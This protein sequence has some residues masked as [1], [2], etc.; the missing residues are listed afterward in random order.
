MVRRK[1][2]A[3]PFVMNF[4]PKT[5]NATGSWRAPVA[6]RS[7]S[8][9]A[10]AAAVSSAV[11]PYAAKSETS[12]NSLTGRLGFHSRRPSKPPSRNVEHDRGEPPG[13]A[14]DATLKRKWRVA[15]GKWTLFGEGLQTPP[16][17][18]PQEVL[19]ARWAGHPWPEQMSRKMS[20]NV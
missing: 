17:G 20:R 15:S 5:E 6:R 4:Q 10:R 2:V 16:F 19:A 12:S 9:P 18:W 14:V 3:V 1:G 13:S 8:A 7:A 11:I